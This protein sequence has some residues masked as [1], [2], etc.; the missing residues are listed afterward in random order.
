MQNAIRI[1]APT[2]D[3]VQL[4]VE[5]ARARRRARGRGGSTA[6]RERQLEAWR[7][8]RDHILANAA[9]DAQRRIAHSGAM[10]ASRDATCALAEPG[11][12]TWR[13]RWTELLEAAHDGR[14]TAIAHLAA[15]AA[16]EAAGD[17]A[18]GGALAPDRDH[19]LAAATAFKVIQQAPRCLLALAS[20]ARRRRHGSRRGNPAHRDKRPPAGA[21]S[22]GSKR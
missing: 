10:A 12:A 17:A 3:D 5:A 14:K 6:G 21:Q 20:P 8:R 18:R 11:A 15:R 4:S 1:A 19:A 2:P 16:R 13:A 7:E 22:S 9:Q